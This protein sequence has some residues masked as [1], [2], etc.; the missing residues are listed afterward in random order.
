MNRKASSLVVALALVACAW[1]SVQL[2][3]RVM[4]D[5]TTIL[6]ASEANWAVLENGW[7]RQAIFSGNLTLAVIEAKGPETGPIQTHH[8]VHDQVTYLIDGEIEVQI[9]DEVRRIGPG[10]SYRVPSDVP[11]GIRVLSAKA[12]LVDAFTPPREDFR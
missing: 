3:G 5:E 1:L 9:G 6:P 10:G 4:E 8:H 11:H 2:W 7:R 12:R